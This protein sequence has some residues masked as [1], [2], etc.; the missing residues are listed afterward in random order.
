MPLPGNILQSIKET[1]LSP[2]QLLG[3]TM[4]GYVNAF[5]NV[6]SGI[7]EATFTDIYASIMNLK[8]QNTTHNFPF[9][10]FEEESP[11]R[12]S[13][14]DK[15]VLSK[16]ARRRVSPCGSV[17]NTRP[18]CC[19]TGVVLH[20]MSHKLT[21]LWL[22]FAC[23]RKS[24]NA[25]ADPATHCT[26]LVGIPMNAPGALWGCSQERSLF[27]GWQAAPPE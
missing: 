2:E 19:C 4:N 13:V 10:F 27:W 22:S 23:R 12:F 11:L 14:S 17:S 9:P 3:A 16:R 21:L 8:W 6:A 20:A 25:S 18:A 26:M 24:C 5:V 7:W 15:V 1:C